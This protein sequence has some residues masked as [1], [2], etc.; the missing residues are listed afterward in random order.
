MVYGVSPS[1]IE[2]GVS[3]NL[4]YY[5]SVN[6]QRLWINLKAFLVLHSEFPQTAGSSIKPL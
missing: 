4:I 6:L 3:C 2:S 5:L 1:G